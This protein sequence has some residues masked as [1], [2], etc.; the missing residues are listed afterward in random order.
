MSAIFVSDRIFP[1]LLLLLYIL[2]NTPIVLSVKLVFINVRIMN[3]ISCWNF[4]NL[5]D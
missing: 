4:I 2:H 1:L 3:D 5:L